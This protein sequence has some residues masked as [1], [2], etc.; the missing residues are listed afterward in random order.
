MARRAQW[1]D[2]SI[3]QTMGAGVTSNFD[4]LSNLSED[5]RRGHTLTRLILDLTFNSITV[6][7]A[8]G[9]MKMDLGVG[10]VSVAALNADAVPDPSAEA[11][12]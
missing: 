7:G 12:I 6:A 3:A 8:W 2:E 1:E 5:E 9:I 11:Q 4:L 10:V